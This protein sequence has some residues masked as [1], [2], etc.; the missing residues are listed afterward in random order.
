MIIKQ[1]QRIDEEL[2]VR[3]PPAEERIGIEDIVERINRS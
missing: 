3:I 2:I 1:S